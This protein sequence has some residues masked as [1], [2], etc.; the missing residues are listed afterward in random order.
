MKQ[1]FVKDIQ[2][3]A[4][5]EDIFALAEK[6]V[7]QK[8]DGSNY[9]SLVLADKTGRIK[10]VMWDSVD[11]PAKTI[12]N[13]DFI[14]IQGAAGEYRGKLQVV[15]KKIEAVLL[16]DSDPADFLPTTARDIDNMFERLQKIMDTLSDTDLIRLFQRF[17]KDDHF[18]SKF[19]R[20]P[21]GK[22]MHHAYIGGLL[23]HTLSMVFLADKISAHYEGVHRDL[24]L[25][26]AFLHDIGKIKEFDY[27]KAI[28]YSDSGRFLSHI[29][30][31][32]EMI[33][34]KL[35][36]LP[37]FPVEKA[38][39]VKHMVVSHHGQREFGAL[40]PPKPLEA[41][42][43]HY[44]DEIDSKIN[45]IREFMAADESEDGWT[46]Y[47]RVLGRHFYKRGIH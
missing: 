9:L 40:E 2:A 46:S 15:I 26:G 30:I 24:L 4:S 44:I 31:G 20:A 28:D 47:H 32:L 36:E 14:R 37:G 34:E 42:L 8:K 21:A 3:G 25:I 19:K 38:Q 22:K 1:I 35:L 27:H 10:A 18:V 33:G 5:V 45:G 23:E 13:G 6:S 17:W 7:L 11:T 39:Q 16:E 43:L 12:R 29:V 41:V